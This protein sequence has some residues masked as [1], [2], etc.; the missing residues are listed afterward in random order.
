[1]FDCSISIFINNENQ[2]ALS[3]SLDIRPMALK[4]ASLNAHLTS[5]RYFSSLA[6]DYDVTLRRTLD[7]DITFRRALDDDITFNYGL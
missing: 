6:L 2:R 1:M 7:D 5:N 3:G 4:F